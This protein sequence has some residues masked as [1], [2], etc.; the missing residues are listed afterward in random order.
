M[1]TMQ[2]R[3]LRAAAVLLL[4]VLANAQAPL[5]KPLADFDKLVSQLKPGNVVG[6][7]IQAGDIAVIPFAAIQF[8]LGGGGVAAGFAGG[9]GRRTVPLGILVV[10]G[11]DVRAEL[12]PEQAEKPTLVREIMQAIFERKVVFM[13]N[14]LNIGSATGSVQELAPLISGMMGQTN[15][16]GNALNLGRM[17][18]PASEAPKKP[19]EEEEKAASVPAR[20]ARE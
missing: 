4:G 17:A 14:G 18:K 2:K 6:E 1:R 19:A 9:M 16:I 12:F 13:G 15:L 11:D 8:T 5:E 10:E 7:T 3:V 20:P